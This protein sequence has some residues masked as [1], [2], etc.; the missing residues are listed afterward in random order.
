[1]IVQWLYLSTI[2]IEYHILS[3]RFIYVQT[4]ELS[5]TFHLIQKS[6]YLFDWIL[7]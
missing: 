1:M 2:L 6:S 7:Q 4:D 5:R 3:F